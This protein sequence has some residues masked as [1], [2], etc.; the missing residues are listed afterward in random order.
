MEPRHLKMKFQ[1]EKDKHEGHETQCD[2]RQNE[3]ATTLSRLP[4][5]FLEFQRTEV[6]K[7]TNF[8]FTWAR[9]RDR[10]LH[11]WINDT[12]LS[13]T[14]DLM[15]CPT[16]CVANNLVLFSVSFNPVSISLEQKGSKV[17]P[18]LRPPCVPAVLLRWHWM[19]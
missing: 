17:G 6:S 13:D 9:F 10:K 12:I 1:G 14:S 8:Y 3:A 2:I 7:Q 19:K 5:G 4:R 11:Q 15:P 18:G 16:V